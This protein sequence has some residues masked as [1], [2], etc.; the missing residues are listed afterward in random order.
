MKRALRINKQPFHYAMFLEK[1][2]ILDDE[3]T[4]EFGNPLDTGEIDV[5]Y[6][7]PIRV[8]ANISAAKGA[9][10]ADIFGVDIA[11]DRVISMIETD[12]DEVSILWVDIEPEIEADGSTNTPHNYIVTRKARSLNSVLLAIQ[13]VSVS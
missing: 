3:K 8:A 13:K 5:V 7:N 9:S 12:I 10:E 4:D 2:P 1:R 11:Y 6:S